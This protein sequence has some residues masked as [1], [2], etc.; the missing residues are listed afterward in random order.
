MQEYPAENTLAVG[1]RWGGVSRW[2]KHILVNNR[3]TPTG[4]GSFEY[5]Y[6]VVGRIRVTVGA[7]AFE[8]WRITLR[9]KPAQGDVENHEIWFVPGVGEVRTNEGLLL[10]DRNFH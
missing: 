2:E 8:A 10:V 1:A 7:G 9:I 4:A 5:T 6:Q 3:L